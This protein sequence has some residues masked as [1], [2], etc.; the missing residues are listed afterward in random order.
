MKSLQWLQNVGC[1][2]KRAA[3]LWSLTMWTFFCLRAP[4][5]WTPIPGRVIE[6]FRRSSDSESAM[7]MC[8]NCSST[9]IS[10]DGDLVAPVDSTLR[11]A[12]SDVGSSSAYLPYLRRSVDWIIDELVVPPD[13]GLLSFTRR[14]IAN[15]KRLW[16]EQWT[17]NKERYNWRFAI[18]YLDHR[19]NVK[20][21]YTPDRSSEHVRT[22]IRL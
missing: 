3:N 2:K 5:R 20:S 11:A 8:T 9:A 16:N 21:K 12:S 6:P 15:S 18:N 10:Y 1:L 22:S 4:R 14:L 7:A 19:F 17:S 13:L